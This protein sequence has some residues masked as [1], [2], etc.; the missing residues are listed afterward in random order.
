MLATIFGLSLFLNIGSVCSTPTLGLYYESMC[1]TSRAFIAKEV[2]PSYQ[3]LALY[4][5][6]VF[7]AY[8]KAQTNG[9]LDTGYSIQCSRGEEECIGNT[10]Q[11]CTVHYI[12]DKIDQAYLIAC[13]CAAEDPVESARV[14][15]QNIGLDYGPVQACAESQ[16]G[17]DLHYMN[18]KLTEYLDPRL[19]GV[20]WPTW[21]GEGGEE[22]MR[23]LFTIG[24][25]RYVCKYFYEDNLPGGLCDI[26][27]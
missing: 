21:D 18:G 10:I 1:P 4:M 26:D 14:C 25:V 5:D 27:I 3:V 8:G 7:V 23:E 20:P 6:V 22:I 15:Y 2:W 16:E 9:S 11:A 24:V 12:Q 13:M 19:T 17:K